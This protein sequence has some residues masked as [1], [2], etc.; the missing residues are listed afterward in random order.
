[1]SDR[2]ATAPSTGAPAWGADV[3][4]GIVVS[5]V[6]LPL[7]LGVALASGAPLIAGLVTGVIGGVVVSWLGGTSLLVSGPA[8]GLAAIVLASIAQ[9]GSFEALLAA[10]FV[11]GALQVGLGLLRAGRLAALVPSSV[12][13]GML[14]AIGVLLVLQ[15]SPYL[16][17]ARPDGHVHGFG[18]LLV[19]F[20][21]L[22]HALV[23]PT[24]VGLVCLALLFAWQLPA[25]AA[26]RKRLPGPLAAVVL[27]VALAQ[28]LA[29]VPG[30]AVPAAAYVDLPDLSAGF[31][32]LPTPDFAALADSATWRVAVTL[33]VVASLETLL[34]ME[35][36]DRLDPLERHS[37]GNRELVGQG[38]G[39]LLA[40]LAGGLP[41]TGV[42]VRSAANINAGGR[43]WRSAFVHGVALLAAVLAVPWL[44]EHIPLAALAAVLVHTGFGLARPSRF[45][46]AWRIGPAFA[47]PLV[48]TVVAVVATDLL[49]GVASGLVLAA[50][51]ALAA[52]ARHGVEVEN[53][54]DS[55]R[56]HLSGA[57][58]FVHR[59][60][61]HQALHAA[62]AG[63]VVTVDASRSRVIDH[64]VAELL[65]GFAATANARGIRYHLIN[66]PKPRAASAH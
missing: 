13:A 32:I 24:L 33:A 56:L 53:D 66:V 36:T 35:A 17:G 16:V 51:A 44:L 25:L 64:D 34:S 15:Q 37:D 28:A 12:V 1:V 43:T 46:E 21:A 5:L 41:M 20:E 40:G 45:V 38:V 2:P 23:G 39:N 52:N 55:V 54:A 10:T 27:G 29:L 58:S 63:A 3:T 22:P 65:H 6:A 26:V 50:G 57:V 14:A 48:G 30:L 9:L 62:P 31:S 49:V 4:A 47:L 42:I 11:A 19:P 60:R 59:P 8:A 18:L 7:C 61:L